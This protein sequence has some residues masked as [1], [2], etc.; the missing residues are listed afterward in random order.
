MD[1]SKAQ[2][3][4]KTKE[5]ETE[6]E[7][8]LV[9]VEPIEVGSIDLKLE[10]RANVESLDV[11]SIIPER[12]DPVVEVLVEEGDRVETGQVLARLRTKVCELV[13]N[14]CEVR[15]QEAENGRDQAKRNHERNVALA[16]D[17]DGGRLLTEREMD[18]SKQEVINKETMFQAAGVAHDRAKFDLDNCTLRAPISGT[19]TSRD[20]SV[21]D[22]ASVGMQAFQ[23]V[24]TSAPKAIFYRPQREMHLLRP[25]QKLT[26]TTEALPGITLSGEIERISPTVDSISGTVKVTAALQQGEYDI[27]I[28]VMV[29]IDLVLDRHEEALLVPKRA[30]LFEGR[31]P[32]CFVIRDGT[33]V[34]LDSTPGFETPDFLEVSESDGFLAGDHVVVVGADRLA[35]GDPV[36]IAEQ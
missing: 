9:R 3:E 17:R 32:Y 13:L 12:A 6:R 8:I 2:V 24:D 34:R 28:G 22:Y 23:I 4:S 29:H 10:M 36:K 19:V 35:P 11:V 31:A 27:P 14:E 20:I 30:L 16:S 7:P 33:A 25:G 1:A 18:A 5:G 26:A 15:L 21:G